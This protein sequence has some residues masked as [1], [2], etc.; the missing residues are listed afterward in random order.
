[1]KGIKCKEKRG[2]GGVEWWPDVQGGRRKEGDEGMTEGRQF[3]FLHCFIILGTEHPKSQHSMLRF[4]S[5]EPPPLHTKY[6][7]LHVL[8]WR[9]ST[10]RLRSQTS[11]RRWI[12][13]R[14]GKALRNCRIHRKSEQVCRRPPRLTRSA[15]RHTYPSLPRKLRLLRGQLRQGFMSAKS[16]PESVYHYR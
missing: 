3:C 11:R 14:N 4:L 7:G 12:S 9:C 8:D 1:M 6:Y 15:P 16:R 2:K 10:L 5:L 13:N